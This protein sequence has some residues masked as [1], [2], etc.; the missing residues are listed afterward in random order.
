MERKDDKG[1]E[2]R[3]NVKRNLKHLH[4]FWLDPTRKPCSMGKET[5]KVHAQLDEDRKEGRSHCVRRVIQPARR[6]D[7]RMVDICDFLIVN[8]D[9]ALPTFGT[10]EEVLRAVAQ[11]KP[12]LVHLQSD[13]E[14][15][16]WW[17]DVVNLDTVFH[18]WID[19][20]AY[21]HSVSACKQSTD[22]IM[23]VTHYSWLFFDWMG[24]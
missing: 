21:L 9:P 7:L 16:F 13:G 18:R 6:I 23:Q 3:D 20:Y 22:E 8:L 17:Y 4:I 14:L 11:N 15:P 1:R 2:W 12:V 24:E 10:H 19:L 5:A